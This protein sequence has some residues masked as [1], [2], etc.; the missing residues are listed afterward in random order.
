MSNRLPIEVNPF[1]LIE[2]RRSLSGGVSLQHLPRLRELVLGAEGAFAVEMDFTHSAS[3]LPMIAGRVQGGVTLACQ[4][5]LEPVRV[6]V[7]TRLNVV[8]TTSQ[9][10]REPEE[11]GY[12]I[13]IVDDERLFLQ[14]F[15][16]DEILLALP[17]VPR[18]DSCQPVRPLHDASP[19]D[20]DEH[21]DP[22]QGGRQNPF[23]A[24]KDWKKTE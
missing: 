13:Y 9:T 16:E 17:V 21:E 10:D 3:G 7:D 11:E 24:L 23:A 8:L 5:C 6:G 18:H 22:A 20:V 14:D 15:I 2:Q 1:R 4:R 19:D 12:E